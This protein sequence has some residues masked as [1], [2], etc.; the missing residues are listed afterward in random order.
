[1]EVGVP[2]GV[3]NRVYKHGHVLRFGH[4]HVFW[5]RRIASWIRNAPDGFLEPDTPAATEGLLLLHHLNLPH[6]R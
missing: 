6:A 2:K 4:R 3:Q 1:M 5:I